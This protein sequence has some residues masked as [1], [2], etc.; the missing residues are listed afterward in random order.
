MTL[1]KESST[2][3]SLGGD[4][5]CIDVK[6]S[7][8]QINFPVVL[9]TT[10]LSVC[11]LNLSMAARTRHEKNIG[12]VQGISKPQTIEEGSSVELECR[13]VYK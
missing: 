4:D 10:V 12:L 3:K 5:A 8:M 9:I 6:S 11:I 7:N 1:S 2:R 13:L